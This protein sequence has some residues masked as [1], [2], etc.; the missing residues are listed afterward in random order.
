MIYL[1]MLVGTALGIVAAGAY[2]A[3]KGYQVCSATYQLRIAKAENQRLTLSLGYLKSGVEA[4]QQELDKATEVDK[5][6][7]ETIDGLKKQIEATQ[8]SD[9]KCNIEPDFLHRLDTIR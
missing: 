8:A 5:I 1:Y 4:A 6:N 9:D 7:T 3:Y 2:G